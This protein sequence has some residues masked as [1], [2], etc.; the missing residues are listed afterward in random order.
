M[1]FR[2]FNFLPKIRGKLE[3]KQQT[4]AAENC[5]NLKY[6]FLTNRKVTQ[7]HEKRRDFI[8][9]IHRESGI[10]DVIRLSGFINKK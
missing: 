8:G 6:L 5:Q 9:E 3:E 10:I 7:F 4:M 1:L 2:K